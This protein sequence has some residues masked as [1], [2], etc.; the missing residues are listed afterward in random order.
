MECAP[1]LIV[2]DDLSWV[3]SVAELL[4]NAGLTVRAASN[5]EQAMDL[6]ATEQPSLVILDVHL[7]GASGIE[8]LRQ[9][10]Q[11]D[12]HTPVL[13]ISADDQ[14]SIQDRAMTEGATAFLRKP[15]SVALLLR[16]VRRYLGSRDVSVE[17]P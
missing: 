14:A 15:I 11:R 4:D 13:M 6:L 2:D 1:V 5:G 17:G 8:L 12:H 7:R 16:A 3:K 9:F 10:R